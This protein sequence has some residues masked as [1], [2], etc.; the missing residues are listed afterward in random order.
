MMTGIG[1]ALLVFNGLWHMTEFMMHGR[2]KDTMRLIVP[3]LI[4]LVLGILIVGFIGGVWPQYIAIILTA[5]GMSVAINNIGVFGM[6]KWV[7][8]AYILI[9]AVIII[10]LILGLFS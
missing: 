8:S 5:L 10:T 4:Y 2:N 3:G 7:T 9:D 1:G 6:P